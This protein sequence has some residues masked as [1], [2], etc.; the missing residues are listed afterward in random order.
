[1]RYLENIRKIFPET[2]KGINSKMKSDKG[3]AY[4]SSYSYLNEAYQLTMDFY[5]LPE[6]PDIMNIDYEV[7]IGGK[8]VYFMSS[9]AT[10]LE[11]DLPFIK[12]VAIGKVME[13]ASGIW[14][15]VEDDEI[16]ED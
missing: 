7:K 3:D 1:M 15:L 2:Q 10:R 9:P 6:R 16:S 5:S 4:Y 14:S 8:R 11:E 12:G 13:K